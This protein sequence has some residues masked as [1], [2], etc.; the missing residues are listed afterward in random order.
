MICH[1]VCR[2]GASDTFTTSV[3]TGDSLQHAGLY[4]QDD[5]TIRQNALDLCRDEEINASP[6]AID[7]VHLALAVHAADAMVYRR[8][9]YDAWSRAFHLYVPV[10]DVA[11]WDAIRLTVESMLSFLSGDHYEI[12]FRSLAWQLPDRVTPPL[13]RAVT[14]T[15][16]SLFSGGMDSFIGAVDSLQNGAT[17]AL[18]GHHGAGTTNK[19]QER[20]D[21]VLK[22]HYPSRSIHMPFYSQSF[23]PQKRDAEDSTRSRSL[24]F[25][26]LGTLVADAFGGLP[27]LIPENG[28]ISLNTPLTHSRMGSLSTRT[29]HAHFLEQ[30][31]AVLNHLG[32]SVALDTPY[33]FATKGEMANAVKHLP[34]FQEGVVLTMSCSHPDH[35]RF[36]KSS[37]GQHCGYCVPCIIRRA[38][39]HAASLDNPSHYLLDVRTQAPAPKSKKARDPRA[40]Q[41]AVARVAGKSERAM[42][43]DVLSTG[44][45]PPDDINR[46]VDVYR[47]GMN[48]IRSFLP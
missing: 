47:R 48:E 18:V 23:L 27:L 17:L 32:I 42:L 40:F 19:F 20:V 29:T 14:P 16:V 1:I 41:M 36:E 35:G 21:D 3:P 25:L 13:I 7:I 26:S 46:R 45:L 44:P 8:E 2:I 24:L 39:M 31:A 30:F 34:A 37:P 28:L 15:A 4:R 6:L 11:R 43:A 33:C 5:T 9:G 10:T 38:A 22:K 12:T